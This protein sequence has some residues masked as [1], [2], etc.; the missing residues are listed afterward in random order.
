MRIRTDGE[1]AWRVDVIERAADLLDRNKTAAVTTAC[2][3]LVADADAKRELGEWLVDEQAAGRLSDA[4]VE[5]ITTILSGHQLHVEPS[6]R[7]ER[8][9]DVDA[10]PSAKE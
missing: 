3:H 8:V 9:V 7:A 10:E 4:Q 2:E 1:K 5:E 6:Y